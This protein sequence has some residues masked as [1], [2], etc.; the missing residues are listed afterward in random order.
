[1]NGRSNAAEE[2]QRELMFS[3]ALLYYEK[4]RSQEE[5]ARELGVSRPTV[6]RLLDRARE[7][8]IVRIEVVPPT[9]DPNLESTLRDNLALEAL[10]IAPAAASPDD[11]GRLVTTYVERSLDDAGLR[12]GDAVLVS[13]GRAVYSLARCLVKPR[14]GLLVAPALGGSDEDKP[15]FQPNEIVR[16]LA[17]A[18]DGTPR[19]L[20]APA[21]ASPSLKRSLQREPAIKATLDLWETAA[22][23]LVGIGNWPKDP[24]I[25]AA[26]FPTQ[27]PAFARATGD[28][29]ARFFTEPGTPVP[30]R[31]EPRLLGIS[32]ERL[33]G[34]PH[35][36][37]VAVGVEKAGAV[38]GAARA[39][40]ISTLVTDAPTARAVVERLQRT[41]SLSGKQTRIGA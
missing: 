32:R 25:A 19:F 9:L 1:V 2:G 35:V 18:F 23:A 11:P 39:A 4:D 31:A 41:A 12:A 27:D 7:L 33:R 36:I 21:F 38:I 6:S 34:I 14:P 26:G 28:V 16:L 8:G 37:G 17:A 29:A 3:A 40:L 22:V 30:Y 5:I 20:H 10:H 13:W 15:W 24:G